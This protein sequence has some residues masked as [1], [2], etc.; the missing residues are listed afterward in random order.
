MPTVRATRFR[1]IAPCGSRNGMPTWR[2]RTHGDRR[3]DRDHDPQAQQPR[4]R[5][6]DVA[7]DGLASR[8][9]SS[10]GSSSARPR[11]RRWWVVEVLL[12]SARGPGAAV[13]PGMQG[14]GVPAFELVEAR[15][16]QGD[17]AEHRPGGSGR[18]QDPERLAPQPAQLSV[19]EAAE[20]TQRLRQRER[21]ALVD[22]LRRASGSDRVSLG[23]SQRLPGRRR[24]MAR[25]DDGG[26]GKAGRQ[27]EQQAE[28]RG[29]PAERPQRVRSP[30]AH[31]Q[32]VRS[33]RSAGSGTR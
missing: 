11:S 19:V 22:G 13:Q 30:S 12:G 5:R 15:L 25:P 20:R 24:P 32:R 1:K 28:R 26:R 27:D 7:R 2:D 18:S 33:R 8:W 17:D 6:L 29:H 14:R 3:E 31:G 10:A 21:A 16:A 9:G 23:Q 4:A